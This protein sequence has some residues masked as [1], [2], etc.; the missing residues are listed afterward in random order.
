MPY[1]DPE[2][3]KAAK[4]RQF[5]IIAGIVA[6]VVLCF[7]LYFMISRG[8]FKKNEDLDPNSDAFRRGLYDN[9]GAG[10]ELNEEKA[11]EK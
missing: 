8:V 1:I 11:I 10:G 7:A 4:E 9:P 2:D 5:Q 6:L 3:R